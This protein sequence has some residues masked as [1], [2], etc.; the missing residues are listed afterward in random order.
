MTRRKP[1]GRADQ[2]AAQRERG[3]QERRKLGLPWGTRDPEDVLVG[4]AE[5]QQAEDM[6]FRLEPRVVQEWDKQLSRQIEDLEAIDDPGERARARA[7]LFNGLER[8]ARL[9]RLGIQRHHH[10]G[11][12]N[13]QPLPIRE[14]DL[15]E[16]Q[17]LALRDW[18]RDALE[19]KDQPELPPPQKDPE[20]PST[21]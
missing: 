11:T 13:H 1:G 4:T 7:V 8:L 6:L 5:D 18:A 10:A 3:R 19:R 2:R 21:E 20:N 14:Q 17:R 12:I 15:S 16:E 9:T